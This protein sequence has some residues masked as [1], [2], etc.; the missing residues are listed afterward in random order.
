MTPREL[1]A[2]LRLALEGQEDNRI[3]SVTIDVHHGRCEIVACLTKDDSGETFEI[4]KNIDV[5]QTY[6]Y[7][8]TP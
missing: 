1:A 5:R 3:L 2:A 4:R 6:T 8:E 7:L